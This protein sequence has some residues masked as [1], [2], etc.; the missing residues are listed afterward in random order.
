MTDQSTQRNIIIDIVE[1]YQRN[2]REIPRQE[3]NTH[4]ITFFP[5]TNIYEFVPWYICIQINEGLTDVGRTIKQI[6]EMKSLNV[7]STI[8]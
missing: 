4:N 8:Q 5:E 7:A 6:N 1:K 2:M 3:H